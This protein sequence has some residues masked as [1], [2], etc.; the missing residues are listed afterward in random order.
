VDARP[1][2]VDDPED[3]W[4]DTSDGSIWVKDPDGTWSD[5]GDDISGPP[6]PPG[7]PGP[8]GGGLGT[9][10]WNV[11]GGPPPSGHVSLDTPLSPLPPGTLLVTDGGDYLVS[12]TD[13][14][15]YL[16]AD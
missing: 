15:A 3:W 2:T 9:Y 6:G 7:P 16:T 1:P 4:L 13:P 11:E 12:D 8:A 5:T 10:L 14:T